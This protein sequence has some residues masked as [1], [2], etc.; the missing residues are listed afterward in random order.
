MHPRSRPIRNLH[1][2]P[3]AP[4]CAPEPRLLAQRPLP[5]M[6]RA[7]CAGTSPKD[8]CLAV[9]LAGLRSSGAPLGSTLFLDPW[10]WGRRC[11]MGDSAI[12]DAQQSTR[13]SVL[14]EAGAGASTFYS[15]L[16]SLP[17]P[18]IFIYIYL[19]IYFTIGLLGFAS[20]RSP[21]SRTASSWPRRNDRA[22]GTQGEEAPGGRQV[23][24]TVP[25]SGH[26]GLSEGSPEHRT[27][28]IQA[29]G[30]HPARARARRVGRARMRVEGHDGLSRAL[31]PRSGSIE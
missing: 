3:G 29:A 5:S 23:S 30:A 17:I 6:M 11:V 14:R 25:P 31:S 9:P 12:D 7:T 28:H 10:G 18:Y 8:G 13:R 4:R 20:V 15:C 2:P 21:C 24:R 22:S 19:Y 1:S 26:S 27:R 16:C